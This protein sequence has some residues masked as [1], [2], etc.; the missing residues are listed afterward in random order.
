[1][2]DNN[3]GPGTPFRWLAEAF[4]LCRAHPRVMVGAASLLMV[5]ALLPTVAQGLL[6]SALKPSGTTQLVLQAVFTILSLVVFPPMV[7]GFYRLAHALHAGRSVAPFELLSIFQDSR[8]TI[9]LII[10]N[11]I[12]VGLT[13]S[14]VAGLG[15]AFGGSELLEFLRAAALVKPG[16]TDVPPVPDGVFALI[17]IIMVLLLVIVTA[18]GLATAEVAVGGRTPLQ[19]VGAGFKLSMRHLAV[20]LLFYIPVAVIG[21]IVFMI[22]ALVA[23]LI[24]AML[25][26][27]SPVLATALILP[28]VLITVLVV[29]GLMF[30]FF[31]LAW[32]DL[33]GGGGD[34]MLPKD[35]IAA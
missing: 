11:L 24:G 9:A 14:V 7:G 2:T 22:F 29:Y 33:L 32:R 15:Y 35:Q 12:F 23:V 21:F 16:A 19:A 5:A 18:Q 27:I 6:E 30:T 1:M 31:Y 26:V 3:V 10:T 13:L 4:A 17:S 34:R 20:F 8:T 28:V 25:S